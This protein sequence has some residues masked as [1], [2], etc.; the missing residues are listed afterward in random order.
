MPAMQKMMSITIGITRSDTEPLLFWLS[1]P[2]WAPTPC[3]TT[4]SLVSLTSSSLPPCVRSYYSFS[5]ASS[6][7][8]ALKSKPSSTTPHMKMM[9]KKA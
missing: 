8:I 6:L 3:S 7:L 1:S 4:C 2:F 9:V 5:L